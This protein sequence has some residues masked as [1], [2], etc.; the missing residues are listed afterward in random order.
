L[1]YKITNEIEKAS[2]W[3][4]YDDENNDVCKVTVGKLYKLIWDDKDKE[5]C[6]VDDEGILSLIYLVHK[7]D[8]IY[9]DEHE[10]LTLEDNIAIE[11]ALKESKR[12]TFEDADSENKFE[13]FDTYSQRF[14][15]LIIKQR[16]YGL[17]KQESLELKEKSQKT[18]EKIDWHLNEK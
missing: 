3:I 10:Q 17:T 14:V 6:I 7:G 4:P 11:Q 8:F 12:Y 18:I 1:N 15:E 2:H 13:E 9:F 16:D 5:Y